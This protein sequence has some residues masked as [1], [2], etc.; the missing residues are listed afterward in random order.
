MSPF[1]VSG[2]D[3]SLLNNS[4]MRHTRLVGFVLFAAL[5]LNWSGLDQSISALVFEPA[6]K[7]F[8]LKTHYLF[9]VVFHD[10]LKQ[11]SVLLW[12]GLFGIWVRIR[13]SGSRH[14]S[15]IAYLLLSSLAAVF[16]V[17]LL[18]GQ[19][20]HS[21]PWDLTAFGGNAD[22][23]LI[24][25]SANATGLNPGP[26]KCFPSGHA[27]VGWMWVSAC[28]VQWPKANSAVRFG[29]LLASALVSITQVLRGAHFASHVLVSAGVC[30]A[31][32]ALVLHAY[33]WAFK[34]TQVRK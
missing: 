16:A 17:A 6:N 5:A 14:A 2:Q 12:I 24:G 8:P 23:F 21:C 9:S 4:R 33:P 7:I 11:F 26:G 13:T 1:F 32:A 22:F 30:M 31:I 34:R 3:Q 29:V 18:K 25:S 20:A 15:Q 27:S 10:G 19:S 28:L